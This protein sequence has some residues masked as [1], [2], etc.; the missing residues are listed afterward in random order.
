MLFCGTEITKS[1]WADRV[2]AR[3]RVGG[4]FF[5]G[6]CHVAAQAP[7]SQINNVEVG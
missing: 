7:T 6:T 4:Y 3:P 1:G 2:V 5:E